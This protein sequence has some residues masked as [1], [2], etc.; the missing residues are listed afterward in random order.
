MYGEHTLIWI[1]VH[2]DFPLEKKHGKITFKIAENSQLSAGILNCVGDANQAGTSRWQVDGI[3]Q[4]QNDGIVVKGLLVEIEVSQ[5]VADFIRCAW[6]PRQLHDK[7][8]GIS[9][10][11]NAAKL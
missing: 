2:E 9:F 6:L 8:G 1:M 4:F 10:F 5:A 11:S 7:F 3:R